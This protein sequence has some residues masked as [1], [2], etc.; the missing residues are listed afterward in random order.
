MDY[1]RY[2][3]EYFVYPPS[4]QRYRFKRLLTDINKYRQKSRQ[5]RNLLVEAYWQLGL[6]RVSIL[7]R[8]FNAIAPSLGRQGVEPTIDIAPQLSSQADM[9]GW[10]VRAAARR[11]PWRSNCLAQAI[12]AKRMLKKR[13]I[14]STLFLGVKKN[15]EENGP[16]KAHA[17]LQCGKQILTGKKLHGTFTVI[18]M[19]SDTKLE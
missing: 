13:G 17:W 5:E 8:S 12:A 18:S 9:I 10:A 2:K 3:E 19:F 6:V 4:R 1:K 11:T 7:I 16:M 15:A 14:P